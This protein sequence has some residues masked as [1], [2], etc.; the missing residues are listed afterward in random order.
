MC[1]PFRKASVKL[2]A[3]LP[4][5]GRRHIAF[6][7]RIRHIG[8]PRRQ[9]LLPLGF[10]ERGEFL[11]A[12]QAMAGRGVLFLIQLQRRKVGGDDAAFEVRTRFSEELDR[13][14]VFAGLLQDVRDGLHGGAEP[15]LNLQRPPR[16]CERFG[17]P[18]GHFEHR[19]TFDLQ[20]RAIR[21]E[22]L[23]LIQIAFRTV[24]VEHPANDEPLQ[25]VPVRTEIRRGIGPIGLRGHELPTGER[26]EAL[27]AIPRVVI[28]RFEVSGALTEGDEVDAPPQPR[29]A[30]LHREAAREQA[31]GCAFPIA[32]GA[33]TGRRIER[34]PVAAAIVQIAN[35]SEIRCGKFHAAIL[36]KGVSRSALRS[37]WG[38]MGQRRPA[39]KF[40]R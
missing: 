20:P 37:A 19:R 26:A 17:M 21:G 29:R 12:I 32:Q 27:E 1:Q 33:E 13:F 38:A 9:P 36:L 25:R 31:T 2:L 10:D 22:R 3:D 39:A 11:V 7:E 18:F 15:R 30:E 28:D 23:G 6:A 14:A 34:L 5:F 16:R 35:A 40:D 8:T 4:R 24:E